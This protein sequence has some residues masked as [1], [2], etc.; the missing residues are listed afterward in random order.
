MNETLTTIALDKLLA[1]PDNPNRMSKANFAKLVHNIEQTG[2]YEPLVVR[3]HPKELDAFQILNG[4]HRCQ[5]L[6]KLGHKTAQAVVWDVDDEQAD[7]MLTTLN[8]LTGHDILV[9]KL[10]I[11][12]RLSGRTSA[13]ELAKRL[14]HTR[15]QLQRLT[16][17][18][19]PSLAGR[20]DAEAWAVPM[21]FFVNRAD[22]RAIEEALALAQPSSNGTRATRRAAALVHLAK[23]F[24][25]RAE[26]PAQLATTAQSQT[27]SAQAVRA[28]H[29]RT[30][31]SLTSQ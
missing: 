30:R 5:A 7:I 20:L 22:Q 4:H 3:P 18:K 6:R 25:D 31:S 28:H 11:L 2:L 26:E 9:K 12:R 16:D 13:R 15:T 10:A 23:H 17:L 21:V 14:P 8:R 27:T 24:V 19:P 29:R 1:H